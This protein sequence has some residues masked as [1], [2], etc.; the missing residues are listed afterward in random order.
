MHKSIRCF[1]RVILALSVAACFAS[2]VGHAQQPIQRVPAA[3]APQVQQSTLPRPFAETI[4]RARNPRDTGARVPNLPPIV[5]P[6]PGV[7][8]AWPVVRALPLAVDSVQ[9]LT[10]DGS[11][12]LY[13][14]VTLD[15]GGSIYSMT[16]TFNCYDTPI[17]QLN[18]TLNAA[19]RVGQ[20]IFVRFK[21]QPPDY[22]ANVRN[23]VHPS[24]NLSQAE[25]M[26]L[27]R[28]LVGPVPT[29]S[30]DYVIDQIMVFG[31]PFNRSNRVDGCG[32]V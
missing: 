25:A 4:Q 1:Q 2:G 6:P 23:Y 20:P 11:L 17:F 15:I 21:N 24:S 9:G 12:W 19:V 18:N 16:Y 31:F 10:A 32:P 27:M 8:P 13:T 28:S 7:L 30:A 29:F 26:Q 5:V 3:V 22:L 14:L